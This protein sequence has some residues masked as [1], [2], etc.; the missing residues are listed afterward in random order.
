MPEWTRRS[1]VRSGQEPLSR[2]LSR[3]ALLRQLP[4]PP[5]FVVNLLPNS[6][7]HRCGKRAGLRFFRELRQLIGSRLQERSSGRDDRRPRGLRQQVKERD[8]QEESG[9]VRGGLV[10]E[11]VQS[12]AQVLLASCRDP[13]LFPRL[14]PV[15]G[16]C[17]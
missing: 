10:T 12:F 6:R 7:E 3:R 17:A 5:L 1:Q 9:G 15:S 2:S 11:G 4:N 14:A 16:G 8:A 13:I